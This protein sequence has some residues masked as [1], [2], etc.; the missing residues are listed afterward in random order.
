MIGITMSTLIISIIN[1]FTILRPSRAYG[2][3]K[4]HKD[5]DILTYRMIVSSI[6]SLLHDSAKLLLKNL[7]NGLNEPS[8]SVKNSVE[9]IQKIRNIK[10]PENHVM[11]SLDVTS[12]FTNVPN[13]LVMNSIRARWQKIQQY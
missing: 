3:P 11:M 9:F 12:L 4:I 2:L 1:D 6:G 5:E 7:K 13:D 8:F 10:I